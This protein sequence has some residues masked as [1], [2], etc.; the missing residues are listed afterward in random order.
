[1]ENDLIKLGENFAQILNA[2]GNKFWNIYRI[3]KRYT[4]NMLCVGFELS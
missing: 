4:R 3:R 2:S 1:M